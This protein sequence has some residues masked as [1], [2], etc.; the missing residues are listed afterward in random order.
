MP[1]LIRCHLITL[2]KS[3]PLPTQALILRKPLIKNKIKHN[4]FVSL[5]GEKDI[6]YFHKSYYLF[7]YFASN[8]MKT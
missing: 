4:Y 8:G 7:I 5:R 1:V 3:F 2:E 6:Y